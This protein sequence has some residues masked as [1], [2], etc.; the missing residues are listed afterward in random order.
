M[1]RHPEGRKD[2]SRKAYSGK[3]KDVAGFSS[4]C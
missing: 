1:N 4:A 2:V 3:T